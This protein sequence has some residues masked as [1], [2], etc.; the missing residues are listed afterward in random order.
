MML[1]G[2]RAD[3]R[4]PVPAD[5]RFVVRAAEAQALE[6]AAERARDA[7]A[8]RRLADA[9]RTDE[10]QDRR[11]AF[12]IE[13][14]HREV[15]EDAPLH[16]GEAVV[17]VV[18]DAPRLVDGDRLFLGQCPWELDQP[19]EIRAQ[20]RRL[21]RLLGH[22]RQARQLLARM[23]LDF[24]GHAGLRDLLAELRHFRRVVVALAQLLLDGLQLLAQQHLALAP[25]E[26]PLRLLADLLRQPLDFDAAHE[27]REHAVKT[28]L[29]VERLEEVL[30]VRRA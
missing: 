7:L 8:E 11:A 5:L 10:A 24:L 29:H 19:V 17:V 27:E 23:L 4:A 15:L 20:H 2:I 1:P 18:E 22:L 16:L 26:A 21:G 6:L 12:R 3:V 25:F 28:R 14:A 13:L 30:L 9:G